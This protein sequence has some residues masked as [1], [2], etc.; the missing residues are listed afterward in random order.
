[1]EDVKKPKLTYY[2]TLILFSL[3]P[4]VFS[5]IILSTML[6]SRSSGAL[7]ETENNAM[8]SLVKNT[9]SAFDFAIKDCNSILR[10]YSEAPIIRKVL[11][12]PEDDELQ[13]EVRK[14][15]LDFYGQLPG[16]EGLYICSW[17]SVFFAHPNEGLIGNQMREGESLAGL[18]KSMLGADG[19]YNL[20]IIKSPASGQLVMSSYYAIKDENGNPIGFVGGATLLKTLISD[21]IDT[22]SMKLES[23]SF[24]I[25]D[26]A[27]SMLVTPDDTKVGEPVDIEAVQNLVGE[28]NSGR[29]L[30]PGIITYDYQGKEKYAAYYVGASENYIAIYSCDVKDALSSTRNLRLITILSS[31]ILV[32]I[33]AAIALFF[34]KPVVKPIAQIS[35]FTKELTDGNLNAT[36]EIKTHIK[37]NREIGDSAVELKNTLRNTIGLIFNTTHDLDSSINDV[38]LK[39]SNNAESIQEINVAIDDVAKTSQKVAGGSQTIAEKAKHIGN[40]LDQ[41]NDSISKLNDGI[42]RISKS[43]RGASDTVETM[44]HSSKESSDAIND[45]VLRT[46]ETNEAIDNISA[47]VTVIEEITS[48]TNLLSL[49]ASIEAARAGEAGHGFAVVAEEIRKLADS[50]AE[51]SKQIKRIIEN[52]VSL[53]T[54]TVTSAEKVSSLNETEIRNIAET[55]TK[56]DVL[57]NA[58]LDSTKQVGSIQ[59]MIRALNEVKDQLVDTSTDLGMISEGLGAAAEEV[60]ASCQ[61]VT[62]ACSDTQGRTEEMKRM[63]AQMVKAVSFFKF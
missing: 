41:L 7:E 61:T 63:D 32:A 4:L 16:W 51:S 57:S 48:Q 3:V 56:F 45:I 1:M 30:E 43:N 39:T 18:Q 53:S 6:I 50:S 37:E 40:S 29:G 46:K 31:V 27:G 5:V 8:L 47:C 55:Q 33:F 25:V 9:G 14:Y 42:D 49:N 17:D 23:G 36:T 52:V 35:E 59:K 11:N 62:Y 19:V 20:G 24:M 10:S 13:A 58:V 28:L 38:Y 44:L 22:S 21:F 60:S 15:T 34:T 2:S 54:A 26:K 12:A